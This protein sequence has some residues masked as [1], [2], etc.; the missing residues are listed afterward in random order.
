MVHLHNYGLPITTTSAWIANPVDSSIWIVALR[1]L[2][3]KLPPKATKWN[4]LSSVQWFP[5]SHSSHYQP[6]LSPPDTGPPPDWLWGTGRFSTIRTRGL[7]GYMG[8]VPRGIRPG[9]SSASAGS[10]HSAA[11]HRLHVATGPQKKFTT[12]I[13]L[14]ATKNTLQTQRIFVCLNVGYQPKCTGS[15]HSSSIRF[16]ILKAI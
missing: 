2:V 11:R 15:Y 3:V 1:F 10:S 14:L 6:S 16:T 5:L 13:V 4:K 7:K 12:C 8:S 9:S